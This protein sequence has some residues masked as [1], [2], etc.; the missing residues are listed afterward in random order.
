M[1]KMR[2]SI[3]SKI[4]KNK[5]KSIDFTKFEKVVKCP[6]MAVYN[7]T[8]KEENELSFK[9]GDIILLTS[10]LKGESG[11]I[12][13][14]DWRNKKTGRVPSS[15]LT[16]EDSES[17]AFSALQLIDDRD[18]SYLLQLP[19]VE[20]GTFILH[21][22]ESVYSLTLSVL[23][24]CNSQREV[25]HHLVK[26]D[27][28]DGTY[29][30]FENQKF[31][32]LDAMISAYQYPYSV[33]PSFSLLKPY[34][35]SNKNDQKFSSCM[36]SRE[37]VK[38]VKKI[39]AGNF[40]QVWKAEYRNVIVAVKLAQACTARK[41]IAKEAEVMSQFY[42]P[43]LV[44]FLGVCCEPSTEPLML[45]VEFMEGGSLD[46]R[47]R[48]TQLNRKEQLEILFQVSDGMK[49][50]E[51]KGAVHNDLRSA[52]VLVAADHS[53][54]ISDFGLSRFLRKGSDDKCSG[55]YP[56]RWTPVELFR[57]DS[58]YSSRGD[59]WSFGVLMWEV[60]TR[61]SLPYEDIP[62]D[63]E[64]IKRV[65]SGLRLRNPKELG[66]TCDEDMYIK[67]DECWAEAPEK[68]P[69]FKELYSYFEAKIRQCP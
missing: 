23:G 9:C 24:Q 58:K 37:S 53:V 64:V 56:S 31:P 10:P 6:A 22:N 44:R 7:F 30:I 41:D 66:F 5:P 52:N 61:A 51:E 46:C 69:S 47:L 38:M 20:L 28:Q 25:I 11:W 21:L 27:S 48:S 3:L 35:K 62:D 49:Y 16:D 45:I 33:N 42:H 4:N 34:P 13:G 19:G 17:Q 50:I 39:G 36:I 54:K 12:D 68:R 1:Q 2:K 55:V 8:S 15:F 26:Y 18:A 32:S 67:M 60:F 14:V 43:R 59:V 29:S 57:I 65:K 63:D 40:G